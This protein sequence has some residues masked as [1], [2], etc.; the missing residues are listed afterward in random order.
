MRNYNTLAAVANSTI[1][2]Y[3]G[4]EQNPFS[5]SAFCEGEKVAD[6]PDEGF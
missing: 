5:T 6:R 3:Q 4:C 2:V 1:L